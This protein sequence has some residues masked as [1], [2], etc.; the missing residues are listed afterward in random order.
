MI[1]GISDVEIQLLMTQ[2]FTHVVQ[3]MLEQVCAEKSIRF[4]SGAF[5]NVGTVPTLVGQHH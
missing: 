5:S 4:E 1:S 3:G 2:D